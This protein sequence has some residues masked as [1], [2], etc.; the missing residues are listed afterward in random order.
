MAFDFSDMSQQDSARVQA[1]REAWDAYHGNFAPPLKNRSRRGS[2]KVILNR[3][4]PIVDKGV[5]LL[6]GKNVD[7]RI[8]EGGDPN[9]Q[10]W[11]DACWKANRKMAFLHKLGVTGGVTGHAFVKLLRT[12]GYPRMVSLDTTLMR[13]ETAP[14]DV[15]NIQA[16]TIG[17]TASGA[18]GQQIESRQCIE[19]SVATDDSSWQ[20]VEQQRVGKV[21]Q[22]TTSETWPYPFSPI[23]QTQNLPAANAFWGRADLTP[24]IIQLNH[25]I[26]FVASNV[27]RIIRF[28]AHPKTYV[29]GLNGQRLATG[30]D[31]T[32]LLPEGASIG[33][34]EMHSDLSSSMN[35]LTALET[36]LDVSARIPAV[37]LG[38]LQD[39]PRGTISGAAIELLYGAAIE[40]TAS[41]RELY[42]ELLEDVCRCLLA[43]GGF[44]AMTPVE[45]IWPD[46]LP[47]DKLLAAQAA[48]TWLGMGISKKTVFDRLGFDYDEEQQ[49]LLA[50]AQ[51][52]QVLAAAYRFKSG[53]LD[54]PD[55]DDAPDS[56]P[57]KP[58]SSAED[59]EGDS[60]AN[61]SDESA[62]LTTA[63][64]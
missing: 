58:D 29:S 26:N 56:S 32:L 55:D 47:S 13:V 23:R 19:R 43:M 62:L 24:D 25:D 53:E 50:E 39:I 41:K 46:V 63:S 18:Q 14:D 8:G 54:D 1:M 10:A 3:C 64:A 21:W 37:A 38:D 44:D 36:S 20:I 51:D 52:A 16:Y 59:T 5:S 45:I 9:A 57:D 6:F 33:A 12:D 2:D 4:A 60:A 27:S 31:E 61:Q 40:K 49:R 28:H 34:L 48:Q 42:G 7:F 15:E 35:F 11:L 17:Y 30:P 22:T